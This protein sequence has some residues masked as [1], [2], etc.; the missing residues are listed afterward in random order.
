[1]EQ[2]SR[3]PLRMVL[4]AAAVSLAVTVLFLLTM[5]RAEANAAQQQSPIFMGGNPEGLGTLADI[6]VRTSRLR[7]PAGVRSNW[8]THVGGGQLL[9]IESGRGLHQVRGGP[10]HE[11]HPNEPWYT[12]EGVEH[13]HGAHPNEAAVQWTIYGGDVNWLEPVQD[14]AYRARA[15]R[16]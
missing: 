6:D 4:G 12:A 3:R 9:M 2:E 8:H 10:I 13:W 7:F 5:A 14:E 16:P 1:M 11:M 15:V